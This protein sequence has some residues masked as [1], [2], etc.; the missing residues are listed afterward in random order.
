MRIKILA[1]SKKER[2]HFLEQLTKILLDEL[3]YTDFRPRLH[4][5]GITLDI[6]ARHKITLTPL[7]CHAKAASREIGLKEFKR[8]FTRYLKKRQKA[9]KLI[10]LF[11]SF[12]GFHPTVLK[13]YNSLQN[14][15]KSGFYL[16]SDDKIY[17]LLRRARLVG[18]AEA[19]EASIRS[20]IQAE[21]GPR[22]LL[23]FEGR[24]Y[25]TQVVSLTRKTRGYLVLDAYGE[26]V[27]AYLAR[28]LKKLDGSLEGKRFIDLCAREKIL[29]SLI[30]LGQKDVE[31]L[32]KETKEPLSTLR[33]VLQEIVQEK[34]V[35]V[36]A[37]PPPRGRHDRYTLR[38]DFDVFLFLARQFLEGPHRFKF[39]NSRFASQMLELG[40]V[41]YLER[42]FRLKLTEQDRTGLSRL[43][44]VSPS[45]LQFALFAPNES[46]FA[47]WQDLETRLIPPGEKERWR[48][49]CLARLHADILC[50]FLADVG[51][52]H[53]STLLQNK[54]VKAF[55]Y[56]ITAKAATPKEVFFSLQAESR[57][58]EVPPLAGPSY[59]PSDLDLHLEKGLAFLN[60]QEYDYAAE[61]LEAAIKEAKDPQQL[62]LAWTSKGRCLLHQKRYS[63]AIA[64]F[65]EAL[66][67]DNTSKVAWLEKAIC[68]K[69]LG[70]QHGALRCGKRAL[71]IDPSYQEAKEFLKAF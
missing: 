27:G 14:E 22:S 44:S 36:E 55:L 47:T 62:A 18:S 41:P 28:E 11:L 1:S 54:G 66:R 69:E 63:G 51:S 33:N 39:L 3:G 31:T 57:M 32:A 16:M 48:I 49:L 12:S 21:F 71:E 2:G 46:F 29:L 37:G 67:H 50:H 45:A 15:A 7:Y 19:L 59:H 9:K 52:A 64:C 68:L 6:K 17:T 24:F 42:R 10:G 23:F 40:L 65:N 58:P 35:M 43:L 30:D 20:K 61:F 53:F 26:P 4:P 70:D 13:W 5:S 56:R 8:V 60:L 38:Q 25:W 34:L